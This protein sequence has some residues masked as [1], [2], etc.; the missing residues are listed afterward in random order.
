MGAT[1][2]NGA[3]IGADCIVS[4]GALVTEGREFPQRSLIVGAPARSI[5]S[6]DDK[7]IAMAHFGAEAYFMRWQ[8]Y[9]RGFGNAS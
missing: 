8:Q 1:V 2:L 9:A 5:R 3:R 7:G 6:L 4:A